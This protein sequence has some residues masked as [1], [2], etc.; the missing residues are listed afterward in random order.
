MKKNMPTAL[1]VHGGWQGH[2]P[3]ELAE[4]FAEWLRE[5]GFTTEVSDSLDGFLSL[6]DRPCDL[7][8]PNWTMGEITPAQRDAML[9]AVAA[10]SGLAGC[11]GGMGDSF[12]QDTAWQFLTGGQFVAH[13]GGDGVRYTVNVGAS[14]NHAPHWI[15]ED[16]DDFTVESEQYYMHV[17]PAIRVLA[18]TIVPPPEMEDDAATSRAHP[19]L[20][21]PHTS[22]HPVRMPVAWTKLWGEGRIFYCSIGHDPALFEI[23]PLKRLMIR[24]MLWAARAEALAHKFEQLVTAEAD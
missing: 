4:R 10:G 14:G 24:G 20:F 17:D 12:R 21:G 18:S 22:N 9:R 6:D 16:I 5:S 1:I 19:D 23:E 7:I 13:P 2:R 15:T 3:R 11:H 8:V